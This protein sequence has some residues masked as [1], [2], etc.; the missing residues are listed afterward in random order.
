M[1]R[2]GVLLIP[3]RRQNMNAA[4]RFAEAAHEG[5]IKGKPASLSVTQLLGL[6]GGG[7]DD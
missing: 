3:D 2:L 7:A 4:V 5:S 6:C 1:G